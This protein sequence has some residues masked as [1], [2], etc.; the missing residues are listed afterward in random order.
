MQTTLTGYLDDEMIEEI[1]K[2]AQRFRGKEVKV[3]IEEPVEPKPRGRKNGA[4]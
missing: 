2:A 3:T 4:T 1:M